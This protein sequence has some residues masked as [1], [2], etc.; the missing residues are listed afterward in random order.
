[1]SKEY[2]EAYGRYAGLVEKSKRGDAAAREEKAKVAADLRAM[3]RQANREGRV[4]TPV[5]RGGNRIAV[6]TTDA[7]T[8]R[9]LQEEYVRRFKDVP[10]K[11]KRR[12][13]REF[14]GSLRDYHRERLM[15]R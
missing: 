14:E 6:E 2:T 15:G 4:L 5:N 11:F 7:P 8:R 10:V 3:E 1:M 12:D 13:G 9:S